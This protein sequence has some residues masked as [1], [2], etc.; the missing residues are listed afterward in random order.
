MEN[1]AERQSHF[2]IRKLTIGAA[3]VLLGTTLWMNNGNVV[4][5]SDNGNDGNK[6][7]K[8]TN[9]SK[10]ETPQITDDTKVVI[11][12]VMMLL[13]QRKHNHKIK[14]MTMHNHKKL[15]QI[16]IKLKVLL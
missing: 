13:K 1:A 16:K 12:K 2:G 10:T 11:E 3:S 8:A 5:A 9:D 6:G 15:K 4:Q 7:D 14:L